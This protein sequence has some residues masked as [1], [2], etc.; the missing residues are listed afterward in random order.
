MTS[1]RECASRSSRHS[2]PRWRTPPVRRL[3]EFIELS[4]AVKGYA[5]GSAHRRPLAD[6]RLAAGR[7][8]ARGR[9]RRATVCRRWATRPSRL[10]SHAISTRTARTRSPSS[11]VHRRPDCGSADGVA[12]EGGTGPRARARPRRLLPLRADAAG[13]AGLD[14]RRPHGALDADGRPL[15]REDEPDREKPL[16]VHVARLLVGG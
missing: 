16:P 3:F 9:S 15:W 6:D 13:R 8:R 10:G 11:S 14:S 12:R 7:R 1:T 5:D 4:G 2:S